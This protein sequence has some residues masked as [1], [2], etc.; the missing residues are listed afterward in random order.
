MIGILKG[1]TDPVVGL[2]MGQTAEN[3]AFRFGIAREQ[4]D[5]FAVRSHQRVA[6]GLDAGHYEEIVP[7]IDAD[8]TIYREDDGLRRDS[9]PAKLAKLK[10]F[11]D[12]KYRQR[13]AGQQLAD[14][15]RRGLAAARLR[16]GA[17]TTTASN[18]SGAS[19]IRN[20]RRSIRR[21][22]ASGRCMP[23]HRSCSATGSA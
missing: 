15:R 13:H 10:P 11:F 1:L 3:L 5:A 8:G 16:E 6:A 17:A 20:G 14:H 18:R 4:M 23:P 19:S 22:W 12:R 7:L 9:S 21:R 2:S